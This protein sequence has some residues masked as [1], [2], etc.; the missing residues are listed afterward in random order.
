MRSAVVLALWVA[1][2][3]L[4]V[5]PA[6]AAPMSRQSLDRVVAVVND[7]IILLSELER[8]TA[9]HPLLQ[10]GLGALPAGATRTMVEQK[11]REVTV[12]VLD[13]LIDLA[14]LR[15]EAVKFDIQITEE[16]VDNAVADIARQY[17]LTMDEL[18]K[19]VIAS[20]EYGSWADYRGE[21][22]DQI[23]QYKVPHYLATWSV[24][25]AQV[26]EHYRKLTKDESAKVEVQQFVFNPPSQKSGDRD[27]VFAKAQAIARKLREGTSVDDVAA[28][29]EQEVAAR[30]V[31][32][33]DV[34]PALEDALF[35]AKDGQVVG[36]L[37]SGQGYVVFKVLSHVESA[38]LD[39]EQAKD[40][41]RQQLEAEAFIKA[42]NELREQMRAKAHIDIRL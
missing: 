4:T 42:Q 31:G 1:A 30:A 26:R 38:A 3:G 28:S 13:E 33:G 15:A 34:A 16:E 21:V 20:P 8:T 18:R 23:L 39:Y 12:K 10:E 24:S 9:R 7:D 14:L 27:R 41:I 37:A 6:H 36:P 17:E 19:Q 5:P 35:D 2:A 29:L 11:T 32:R 40:R 25:E 22:R